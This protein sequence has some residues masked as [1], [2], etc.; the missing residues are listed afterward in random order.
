MGW[1]ATILI[2]AVALAILLLAALMHARRGIGGAGLLPWDYLMILC[3]I[4]LIAA[5][6]HGVHLWQEGWPLPWEN[7]DSGGG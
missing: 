1:I 7:W 6:T 3:A 5:V 2:A 4:V